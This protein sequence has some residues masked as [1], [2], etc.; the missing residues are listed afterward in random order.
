[1][2]VNLHAG[3]TQVGKHG[4]SPQNRGEF[5]VCGYAHEIPGDVRACIPSAG[6]FVFS[7]YS[8]PMICDRDVDA[9][10]AIVTSVNAVLR[11][12]PAIAVWAILAVL[13]TA[14]GFA[15]ALL[16][17]AAVIPVRGYAAWHAYRDT[18]DAGAWPPNGE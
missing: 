12:R 5:N 16:G 6:T 10:T 8:L 2:S 3:C 17:L 11:N 13:L 1:M 9:I 7:A 18:I 4:D 14:V 15:T